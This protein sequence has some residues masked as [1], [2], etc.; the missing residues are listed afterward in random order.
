MEMTP[1]LNE[2]LAEAQSVARRPDLGKY[3]KQEALRALAAVEPP[4]QYR[5]GFAAV[6]AAALTFADMVDA[7][8]EVTGARLAGVPADPS[9]LN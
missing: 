2:L 4:V 1:D 9:K 7:G 6:I 3:I 8:L 5:K